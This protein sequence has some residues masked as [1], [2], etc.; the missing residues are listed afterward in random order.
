ML[1]ISV[2]ADQRDDCDLEMERCRRVGGKGDSVIAVAQQQSQ[3]QNEK[4]RASDSMDT[5]DMT[6]T[7]SSHVESEVTRAGHSM[8]NESN[9]RDVID[10]IMSLGSS[11]A[12]DVLMG[13]HCQG[14]CGDEVVRVRDAEDEDENVTEMEKIEWDLPD[15][16]CMELCEDGCHVERGISS[17]GRE[18]KHVAKKFVVGEG[19][20]GDKVSDGLESVRHKRETQIEERDELQGD[21]E[22]RQRADREEIVGDER[23]GE[24]DVVVEGERQGDERQQD[25]RLGDKTQV[26]RA[27]REDLEG[28][29]AQGDEQEG[30]IDKVVE[31]ERQGDGKQRD[32]RL[33]ERQ[34]LE[35]LDISNRCDH[36]TNGMT[37]HVTSCDTKDKEPSQL[38]EIIKD[39]NVSLISTQP[40]KESSDRPVD[41][42]R[43]LDIQTV[44]DFQPLLVNQSV[45]ENDCPASECV[46]DCTFYSPCLETLNDGI[47]INHSSAILNNTH[48][49]EDCCVPLSDRCSL[50]EGQQMI[51][52]SSSHAATIGQSQHVV[53]SCHETVRERQ[54]SDRDV[55][56]HVGNDTHVHLVCMVGNYNGGM[57]PA[58]DREKGMKHVDE[59]QDHVS[60]VREGTD[61]INK[62]LVPSGL[63]NTNM[64]INDDDMSRDCIKT[65]SDVSMCLSPAVAAAQESPVCSNVMALPHLGDSPFDGHSSISQLPGD[66]ENA[67]YIEISDTI[68]VCQIEQPSL[69]HA[70]PSTSQ[71][72]TSLLPN[73]CTTWSYSATSSETVGDGETREGTEMTRGSET[74][75]G[76][77][78]KTETQSEIGNECSMRVETSMIAA[79]STNQESCTHSTSQ[80]DETCVT[81]SDGQYQGGTIE[82]V[83]ING[84]SRMVTD[85]AHSN[86]QSVHEQ[87]ESN[88]RDTVDGKVYHTEQSPRVTSP[89]VSVYE[90]SDSAFCSTPNT[91]TTDG[92][93]DHVCN[94][95]CPSH[96]FTSLGPH[97][98]NELLH[99]YHSTHTV[100]KEAGEMTTSGAIPSQCGKEG[101]EAVSQDEQMEVRDQL[102]PSD[103]TVLEQLTNVED[104]SIACDDVTGEKS[105]EMEKYSLLS[106]EEDSHDVDTMWDEKEDI[107][108]TQPKPKRIRT[109]NT[110]RGEEITHSDS[111]STQSL[112]SVQPTCQYEHA[113]IVTAPTSCFP[114]VAR[115]RKP[116]LNN[117]PRL[118]LGL[119][120]RQ[121]CRS[122]HT[123]PGDSMYY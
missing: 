35:P 49:L 75:V 65:S 67:P 15:V 63:M 28:G 38:V 34:I 61:C 17:I 79:A 52:V 10:D 24:T 2:L 115:S 9:P 73:E 81:I 68:S 16:E 59:G 122:L 80:L 82:S 36:S 25:D 78:M 93:T 117:R 112:P 94:I 51:S 58:A 18:E 114:Q 47:D 66:L 100:S 5:S 42:E 57:S 105:K 37:V 1:L 22:Q 110:E 107:D 6:N 116:V 118:R 54:D 7:V 87:H 40:T 98:K 12:D 83:V 70:R 44:S 39:H 95:E 101:A 71:A 109:D 20:A 77:V 89:S 29:E 62:D 33:C 123:L 11:K 27:D 26:Q 85:D 99:S 55:V 43:V 96:D 92:L 4:E 23:V 13:R 31:G 119:S 60:V 108:T 103:Q 102:V 69:P 111:H 56:S 45:K 21:E 8:G 72:H 74:K 50:G 97:G 76:S 53:P 86:Q 120:K 46:D 88:N 48:E 32:Q 106:D 84:T 104:A 14:G 64:D 30:E 41:N 19:S 90:Q 113:V 121:K 91:N 3:E